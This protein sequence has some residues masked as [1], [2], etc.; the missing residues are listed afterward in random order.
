MT[1]HDNKLPFLPSIIV[2]K[3]LETASADFLTKRIVALDNSYFLWYF[4]LKMKAIKIK[5]V[6]SDVGK[7]IL[8]VSLYNFFYAIIN[9]N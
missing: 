4:C 9:E 3:Y 2:W 6:M 5:H 1:P 8:I 7:N